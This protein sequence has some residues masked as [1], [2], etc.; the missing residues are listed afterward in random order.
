[1]VEDE[2]GSN[3]TF[4]FPI[5]NTHGEAPMKAITLSSLSNFHGLSSEYLDTFLLEFNIF[6]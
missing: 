3:T 2:V 4:E 5:G 1:M 6:S